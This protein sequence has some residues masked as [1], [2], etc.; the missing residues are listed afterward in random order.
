MKK[1]ESGSIPRPV[2]AAYGRPFFGALIKSCET[3]TVGSDQGQEDGVSDQRFI[4]WSPSL[5][6]HNPTLQKTMQCP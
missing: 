5:N 6:L 4:Q 2:M 3:A 1:I